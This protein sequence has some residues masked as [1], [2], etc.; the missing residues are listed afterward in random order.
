M[1]QLPRLRNIYGI[2]CFSAQ[3]RREPGVRKSS[4]RRDQESSGSARG[5]GVDERFSVD[6]SFSVPWTHVEYGIVS[7]FCEVACSVCKNMMLNR[8]FRKEP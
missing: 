8:G 1:G 3:S 4:E 7:G 6:L 5:I 2:Y